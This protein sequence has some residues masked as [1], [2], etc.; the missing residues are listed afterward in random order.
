VTGEREKL[1]NYDVTADFDI[2][3]SGCANDEVVM[4]NNSFGNISHWAWY[5]NDTY[6]AG[7]QNTKKVFENPG[8]YQIQLR[9][10]NQCEADTLEKTIEIID[11]SCKKNLFIPTGFSPNNDGRNDVLY[12]HAN[13]FELLRFEIYDRLGKIIYSTSDISE[14]W[15]GYING[16]KAESS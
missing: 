4:I 12:V 10:N 13:S 3:Y 6:F 11:C 1:A 7:T 2:E 8:T 14:G 16:Q 5:T 15:D 9:V